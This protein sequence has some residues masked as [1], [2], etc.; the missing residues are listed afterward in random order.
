[1]RD[2]YNRLTLRS[3]GLIALAALVVCAGSA[4]RAEPPQTH[5]LVVQATEPRHS[6]AMPQPPT[7][8]PEPPEQQPPKI[9]GERPGYWQSPESMYRP[10][11]PYVPDSYHDHPWG[12]WRRPFRYL[13]HFRTYGNRRASRLGRY[14]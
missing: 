8:T 5:Q 14:R 13:P 1:M 4:V 2:R 7:P 10:Q 3:S 11:Y 9:H 6:D 12:R